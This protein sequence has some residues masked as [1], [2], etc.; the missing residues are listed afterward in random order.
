MDAWPWF[1]DPTAAPPTQPRSRYDRRPDPVEALS[2]LRLGNGRFVGGAGR[3]A[4]SAGLAPYA[5]VVGCLDPRVPVEAV[6][7]QDHGAICVVR[8]AGHVLDRAVLASVE[9]AVTDLDV[10]LVVVLGHDDCR[11]IAAAIE[12]VRT[13]RRPPGPRGYIA[14]QIAPAVPRDDAGRYS[15][16]RVTRNHVRRTVAALSHAEHLHGAV[17][18]GRIDIVG[19]VYRLGNGHVDLLPP[20]EAA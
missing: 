1:P 2:R 7:G 15:L 11:A 8:S 9:F 17:S 6:F 12:T 20:R 10:P 4:G 5:V 16:E 13:G 3:G 19:A 14:D 18:T